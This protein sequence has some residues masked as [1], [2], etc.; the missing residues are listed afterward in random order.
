L[1]FAFLFT[2]PVGDPI[3]VDLDEHDVRRVNALIEP[4][5]EV[6]CPVRLEC[7]LIADK[8][9]AAFDRH[10]NRIR[11]DPAFTGKSESNF[12]VGLNIGNGSGLLIREIIRRAVKFYIAVVTHR[13]V[14]NLTTFGVRR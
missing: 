1:D 2:V 10:V 6:A 11:K 5:I 4:T 13:P 9:G 8:F 14:G 7:S 3:R 12:R